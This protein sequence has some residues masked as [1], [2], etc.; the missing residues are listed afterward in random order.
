MS[1]EKIS[2]VAVIQFEIQTG[3]IR[4]N[5]ASLQQMLA[6]IN[7]AANTL[8]VLPELWA[9]GLDYLNCLELAGETPALIE[10]LRLIAATKEYIFIGSFLESPENGGSKP[11]NTSFIVDGNGI[12]GKY[13]K[14]YLFALWK[15]DQFFTAGNRPEPIPVG[16]DIIGPL[17]CYDLRFAELAKKHTFKGASI[18]VV[19]AQWPEVRVDHWRILLQARAIE[20]QAFVIGANGCGQVGDYV[21]AGHSMII[22]PDGE[23]IAEAGR[24][25]ECLQY[26]LPKNEKRVEKARERFFSSGERPWLIINKDKICS[27]SHLLD[28]IREIKRQGSRIVFTNG[29]FDLIH[30]GHAD[31]LEQARSYG[32]LLIVGLNS[33]RSVRSLKGENRPVNIEQDRARVLAAL[34]C[35]DFVTV[36]DEDTPLNLIKEIMPDILVKGAD[37][38]EEQIVGAAEVKEAGGRV[39]RII[40][41][42][43]CSTT[44]LIKKVSKYSSQDG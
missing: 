33:D 2:G 43:K 38:P 19:S 28:R 7:P 1:G 34:G 5:K 16:T 8:I 31:Y 25:T 14:Q 37:W 32:D 23:I 35:V 12:V 18:L 6:D 3:D 15:E 24:E 13:R 11:W 42:H 21:L 22:A 9:T 4:K 17:I 40:F 10:E 36:F 27:L 20:N 26:S 30:P 44:A 39:E 41:K 29:C